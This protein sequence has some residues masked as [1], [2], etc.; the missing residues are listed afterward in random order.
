MKTFA[1]AAAFAA[2]LA[3]APALAQDRAPFTGPHIDAVLGYDRVQGGGSH[4]G[5]FVYG[6]GAG[7]DFD[8]G[9]TV[10]VGVETEATGS[11]Q[12]E[13][14]ALDGGRACERAGRDLYLGGRIGAVVGPRTMVYAKAGY[15]NARFTSR[16]SDEGGVE[17]DHA[18]L[19]G[20]RLGVGVEQMLSRNISAKA[21]YRYSN[22]A[23][24]VDRHQLLAGVAYRF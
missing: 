19:D 21:E 6:G 7:W 12:K 23:Q 5:G 9:R 3:A 22:Y 4:D 24:G 2:T 1:F 20:V 17:R 11:T 14:V 10:R 13:C 8:L 15:T 16:V 18:T